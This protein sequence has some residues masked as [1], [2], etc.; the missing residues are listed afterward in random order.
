M[1]LEARPVN[2]LVEVLPSFSVPNL[3]SL[4]LVGID[5]FELAFFPADHFRG[6]VATLLRPSVLHSLTSLYLDA[7]HPTPWPT[8]NDYLPGFVAL[9]GNLTSLTLCSVPDWVARDLD[10]FFAALI[11]LEHLAITLPDDVVQAALRHLAS[12]LRTLDISGPIV[13]KVYAVRAGPPADFDG[14]LASLSRLEVLTLPARERW[15]DNPRACKPA[16]WLRQA[17][18]VARAQ[19][20]RVEFA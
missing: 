7:S 1:L 4:T 20:A 18:A 5:F 17:E 13:V 3:A 12:Q 19:G 16:A 8:A 11:R 9:L 2:D 6:N 15:S 10:R 14:E